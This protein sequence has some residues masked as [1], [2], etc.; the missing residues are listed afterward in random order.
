MGKGKHSEE[1][2]YFTGNYKSR[3]LIREMG[4][5]YLMKYYFCY[6]EPNPLKFFKYKLFF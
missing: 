1:N 4:K 5:G 6:F 3:G 2:I